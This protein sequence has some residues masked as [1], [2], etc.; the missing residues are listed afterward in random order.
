MYVTKIDNKLIIF[1]EVVIYYYIVIIC[2]K[3]SNY[4]PYG[5]MC[6]YYIRAI[7]V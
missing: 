1:N 3:Q 7:I 4:A 6:T 5:C 2:K